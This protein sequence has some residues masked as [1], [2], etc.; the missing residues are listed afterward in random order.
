MLKVFNQLQ[1]IKEISALP[2]KIGQ[3]ILSIKFTEIIY[4]KS[5]DGYVSLFTNSGKEY[6]TDLNLQ[7]LED[8]LP[9]NFLRIQ[10]CFAGFDELIPPKRD[11]VA[12]SITPTRPK[13]SEQVQ[14]TAGQIVNLIR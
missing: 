10:T 3:K 7:E 1:P 2:V 12:S 14:I 4:C 5:C 13:A 11:S 9:G 6:V 8:K